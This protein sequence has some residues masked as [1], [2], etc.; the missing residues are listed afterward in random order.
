MKVS[1]LQENLAKGLGVVG[2]AVASKATLPITSNI[3]LATDRDRLKL[4]ATNLEIYINCW[5]GAK[6]EEEGAITIPARLL[7]DFVNTLPND[8]VNLEVQARTRELHL[9]CLRVEARMK[10]LDAQDFPPIPTRNPD[11]LPTATIEPDLLREAIGQVVFAAATDDTRPVLTGVFAQFHG[12]QLTL[13]AADGFRLSVRKAALQNPVRQD[14]EIII[15][16][17][18]LQELS[19]ILG[20]EKDPIELVIT[21]S[22]GQILFHLNNIDVVSQLIPGS[23][24]NYSQLIPQSSST[25]ITVPRQPFAQATRT[26]AIFAKDGSNI[27]RL[28]ATMGGDLT[29][30]KLTVSSR[31]E[32]IGDNVGELDAIVEGADAKIAF[33]AKYLSDV[34]SVASAQ[35]VTLETTSPSSPGVVRCVGSDDF[36]HVIMPMF[37]QW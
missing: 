35:D 30:G 37:V 29:P 33:S 23:F 5:I 32:E 19:R 18:T 8:K 4:A 34:L 3:L 15:P 21:P 12:D 22:K 17:K 28:Q 2:R 1:C 36:T 13:V 26:A 11:E 9:S 24:P 16:A 25:R 10:G 31:S 20:D 27:I 7:T 6:V 14:A